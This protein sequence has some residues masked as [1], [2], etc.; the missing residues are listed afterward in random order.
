MTSFTRYHYNDE[1]G[2]MERC[3]AQSE[4][5]CKFR[6]SR[7]PHVCIV[8]TDHKNRDAQHAWR[9]YQNTITELH[10]RQQQELDDEAAREFDFEHLPPPPASYEA[11]R[12][13]KL[14]EVR[15]DYSGPYG[16]KVVDP[17]LNKEI[18]DLETRVEMGCVTRKDKANWYQRLRWK[19]IN[20]NREYY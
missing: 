7:R 2:R 9:V 3:P 11:E 5:N 18:K 8:E 6:N 14:K 1:E 13:E 19:L 4:Q 20:S 16:E 17:A 15:G 12:L 10:K